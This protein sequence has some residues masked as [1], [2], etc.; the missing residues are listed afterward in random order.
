MNILK[1]GLTSI[2]ALAI[3]T[4]AFSQTDFNNYTT[5]L[6]KGKI[7]EDFTK[8]TYAKLEEDLKKERQELKNSQ[9]KVFVEGTN[10]AIDE[11]LHSGLVV[12]G[13]EISTYVGEIATKLLQND[14]ALRSKLRFY[15]IKS[16]TAKAFSTDQGI[17]FVTTG[18][19]AQ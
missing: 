9:E 3:C 4:S 5:L 8:Q 17:L 1:S 13:D 19:I 14:Y 10:Y 6:S 18:L 7:P 11:I 16:N 15:T 12:F 2:I